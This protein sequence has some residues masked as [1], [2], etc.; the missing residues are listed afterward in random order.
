MIVLYQFPPAFGLPNASPFC[1]K[2]E[3]WLRMAQLAGHEPFPLTRAAVLDVAGALRAAGYRSVPGY[4]SRAKQRHVELGFAWTSVLDL[5]LSE[6]KRSCIRGLP[7]ARQAGDVR[8]D[9][10]AEKLSV[11]GSWLGPAGPRATRDVL[12]VAS[13]WILREIELAAARTS[14]VRFTLDSRTVSWFLPSS[15]TDTAASGVEVT[16]GCA[17]VFPSAPCPPATPCPYCAMIRVVHSLRLA[18]PAAVRTGTC[19][20]AADEGGSPCSKSNIVRCIEIAAERLGLPTRRVDGSRAVSGQSLRV[21]GARYYARHNVPISRILAI[22]RHS[23]TVIMRY[24]GAVPLEDT[25]HIAQ[26]IHEKG[27]DRS[28]ACSAAD[29]SFPERWLLKKRR[30]LTVV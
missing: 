29:T 2:L 23:S 25:H 5:L 12:L 11:G 26:Q 9:L 8:V 16:L 21:S 20:L 6:V 14:D 24:V 19:P 27:G 15:K 28:A 13:L 10:L 18:F 4:L 3:T 7:P 17:P 22:S 30:K 1:M